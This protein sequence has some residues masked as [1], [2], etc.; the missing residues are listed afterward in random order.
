MILFFVIFDGIIMYLSPIVMQRSGI[1]LSMIGII[2]G[3]SSVAGMLFDILLLR[4][5]EKTTFK[6][7]FFYMFLAAATVPFFLFG[8]NSITMYLIAMAA[9]GLYYNLY[10]IGTL[11]FIGLTTVTNQHTNSFGILRVFEDLGYLIAPAFA[12]FSLVLIGTSNIFPWWIYGLFVVAF[13]FYLL[14]CYSKMPKRNIAAAERKTIVS[15]ITEIGIWSKIGHLILPILFLTLTINLVDDAIWTIGPLFSESLKSAHEIGSAFMIAY[16]IPPL[17][18]GWFVGQFANRFNKKRTALTSLL[19]GSLLLLIIGVLTIKALI[20][21]TIFCISFCFAFVWPTINAAYADDITDRS[22]YHELL[23][24]IDDLF[25]N[26]GDTVGPILGGYAAQFLGIQHTFI[27]IGVFGTIA[28]L[29]LFR[30]A[31]KNLVV[32]IR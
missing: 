26:I 28:A 23:E 31:P 2:I 14:L 1:P 5:L 32:P 10:D 12:S 30:Y 29:V 20:L 3:L 22:I 7:I 24:T 4:L 19:I 27:V 16:T 9:W 17:L 13:V 11:D 6:K 25:T 18:V 21:I 15:L 8:T